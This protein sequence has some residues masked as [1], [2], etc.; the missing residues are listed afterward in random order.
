MTVASINSTVTVVVDS[1]LGMGASNSYAPAINAVTTALE[2][3]EYD[4]VDAIVE[5]A[6]ARWGVDPEAVRYILT[7]AGLAERP[8]PVA[9]PEPEAEE[10]VTADDVEGGKPS[11]ARRLAKLEE[12]QATILSSLNALAQSVAGL[13]S[14]AERHLGSSL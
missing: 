13:K 12:D 6:E 2:A 8:A 4:V 11:K 10:S 1:E 3:R 7:E 9:A 5:K 14:L